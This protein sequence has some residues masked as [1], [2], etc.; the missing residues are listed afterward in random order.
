MKAKS[1][2]CAVSSAIVFAASAAEYYLTVDESQTDYGAFTNKAYWVDAN[3]NPMA[4]WDPNGTNYVNITYPG[5]DTKTA[6]VLRTPAV[7]GLVT[8]PGGTISIKGQYS[9]A[10]ENGLLLQTTGT[11]AKIPG[12]VILDSTS[13]IT[14]PGSGGVGVAPGSPANPYVLDTD[15]KTT[16]QDVGTLPIIREFASNRSI[17]FKGRLLKGVSSSSVKFDP[18]TKNRG[19]YTLQFADGFFSDYAC[20]VDWTAYDFPA[21]S[22]TSIRCV[23]GTD[24]CNGWFYPHRGD[25]LFE[26]QKVN[27]V[28]ALRSCDDEFKIKQFGMSHTGAQPGNVTKN[29]SLAY[30]MEFE[31]PVDGTQ[32]KCAK[33][34]VKNT[35]QTGYQNAS[36]VVI[37][38]TGDP[39]HATE[40]NKFATLSVPK[41]A[42]LLNADQ[43]VL[44]CQLPYPWIKPTLSVEEN[45]D[46]LTVY[47]TVPPVS[48]G[49][50]DVVTLVKSDTSS[51]SGSKASSAFTTPDSWSNGKVPEAGHTYLMAGTNDLLMAARTPYPDASVVDGTYRFPEGSSLCLW[52]QAR[53]LTQLNT[54]YFDDLRSYE[55][56][57]GVKQAWGTKKTTG[58][59]KILESPSQTAV[60][61]NI[62][63]ESGYFSFG[64]F[65][66]QKFL[67]K[68]K[69]HGTGTVA[70]S[71]MF[72]IDWDQGNYVLDAINDDFYGKM[73]GCTSYQSDFVSTYDFYGSSVKKGYSKIWVA[74]GRALGADLAEPTFD[75]LSLTDYVRLCATESFT[76]EAKSNRGIS[77]EKNAVVQADEGKSIRIETPI[78]VSGNLYKEGVGV[79]TLAGAATAASGNDYLVVTNGTLQLAGEKAVAGLTVS[80]AA[81]TKL[82][83][84]PF[85]TTKGVDLTSTVIALNPA[86]GGKLPLVNDI[87]MKDRRLT[88]GD[89]D[90]ALFTVPT[91]NATA[92]KA[93]LPAN[94][95]K[96]YKGSMAVWNEPVDNG[97]G[98][99]TFG[100]HVSS[101]GLMMLVR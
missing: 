46:Y 99:T 52:Q 17:L 60:F 37:R 40:T 58:L 29:F 31:F 90:V 83:L 84:E 57:L 68:A 25:M 88:D 50:K 30:G 65:H 21:D 10:I 20:Q 39:C 32:Q 7:E 66:D 9:P 38:L 86:H 93:M 87:G 79:L 70:F 54:L 85:S 94:P 41:A 48:A 77:I 11:G 6:R 78:T 62:T 56:V 73:R 13:R 82:A 8:F 19:N 59:Y 42:N 95:P 33:F 74:D 91:E 69:F 97:D 64:C 28:F 71:G 53:I 3:G 12:G 63:V 81:G 72:V 49:G 76:I 47:V 101:A 14:A 61:G 35:L 15:L 24:D 27:I 44:E 92:F 51:H 16:I 36:N 26:N 23:F 55:G 22:Q 1:V 96:F 45:G 5:N 100:A 75:A 2:L 89:V 80:F 18:G 43:F 98:T 34:T 4:E 67:I